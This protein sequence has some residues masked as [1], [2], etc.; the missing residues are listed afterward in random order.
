M[1]ETFTAANQN[2]RSRNKFTG[3]DNERK[4]LTSMRLGNYYVVK[5]RGRQIYFRLRVSQLPS[6]S[7]RGT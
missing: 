6:F 5:F 7:N 1:D 4:R 2:R 3:P